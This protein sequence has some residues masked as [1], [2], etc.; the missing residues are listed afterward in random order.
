MCLKVKAL[1][2]RF[3]EPEK[4]PAYFFRPQGEL[5]AGQF[6]VGNIAGFLTM[7]QFTE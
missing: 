5:G 7:T 6:M 4:R 3:G 2:G 1:E